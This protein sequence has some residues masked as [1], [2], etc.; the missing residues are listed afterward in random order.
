MATQT[1][2]PFEVP[3]I[4][5]HPHEQLVDAPT[6]YHRFSLD[7]ATAWIQ[8]TPTFRLATDAPVIAGLASAATIASADVAQVISAPRDVTLP[9]TRTCAPRKLTSG[10][11][12]DRP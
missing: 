3:A 2:S 12:S 6:Q 9:V 5:R 10:N 8:G 1:F 4:A 11:R 7:P